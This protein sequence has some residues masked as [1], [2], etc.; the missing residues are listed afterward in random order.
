MIKLPEGFNYAQ[1][2]SD[3]WMLST[4]VIVIAVLFAVYRLIGRGV[5][6]V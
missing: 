5:D 6:S 1:L 4:P 3:F 2:L